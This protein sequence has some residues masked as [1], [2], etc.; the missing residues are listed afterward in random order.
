MPK[1]VVTL[2][3]KTSYD[4]LEF[5]HGRERELFLQWSRLKKAIPTSVQ[6]WLE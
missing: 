1:S 3:G 2:L 5:L 4:L 6:E